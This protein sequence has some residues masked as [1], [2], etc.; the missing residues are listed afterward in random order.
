MYICNIHEYVYYKYIC[1]ISIVLSKRAL[2]TQV[3]DTSPGE[4]IQSTKKVIT[5]GNKYIK[6]FNLLLRKEI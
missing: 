6:M 1:T 3:K 5:R 4:S 2:T